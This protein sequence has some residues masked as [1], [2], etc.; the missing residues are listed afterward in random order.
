[1]ILFICGIVLILCG[2]LFLA[3]P[4]QYLVNEKN[5]KPGQTEDQAVKNYR[6]IAVVFLIL[7][8][9]FIFM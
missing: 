2:I 3:L 6:I 8:I 4:K 9:I 1:M 5:I 7:G